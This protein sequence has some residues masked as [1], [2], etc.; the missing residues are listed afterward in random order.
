MIH[1]ARIGDT[2]GD[3]PRSTTPALDVA[4]AIAARLGVKSFGYTEYDPP[5]TDATIVATTQ[6]PTLRERVTQMMEDSDNVMAEAIGREID[7]TDPTGATRAILAEVGFDLTGVNLLD[8]SGLSVDNLIPPAL[9]TEVFTQAVSNQALR[10]LIGTLPIAGGTGTL[11]ERFE[12]MSGR[13]WVRAKTGTLTETSALTGVVVSQS[14][15]IYS[16]ALLSTDANV[17]DQRAAMD[18]FTSVIRE[19]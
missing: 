15:H 5:E 6:S 18:E 8:S 19:F 16:F 3:V 2:E 12:G 11:Y 17:L 7:G 9:L 13:G 4:G 14:E 1:G 10:P